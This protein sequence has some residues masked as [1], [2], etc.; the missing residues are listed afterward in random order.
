MTVSEVKRFDIWLAYLFFNDR[1]STG[2]VRP[3]LVIDVSK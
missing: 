2:K 3:I 1:P